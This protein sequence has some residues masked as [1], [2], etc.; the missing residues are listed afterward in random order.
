MDHFGIVFD[1]PRGYAPGQTVTGQ[2][3]LRSNEPITA[4]FL[5]ICF[6]G[7]AHT[8]W[9]EGERR[10]RTNCEGKEESYT[11][12][13]HYSAEVD[14]VSGETIA[15]SARNGT[16][17][18]PSGHHVFP[19]AFPLPIECPP[20]FEG[21]HGH[22]RYSVRVE[23]DRPWKFNKNE[24]E[25][26]KVIPNFDLNHLPLGNVP[27]MM[28]DVKDIGQI[29]K[30]GIVTI[31]VTIPKAGYAPG[32]YLPITIDIDNASKRAATFVRAELHQHSHYNA[33]KNHGLL[34]THSSYHEHHKDES[35]RIAEARKS[36]KIAPKTA[37]REMLRMKI[38]KSPPTFTSPIISIE[39]CLSVRLDT[40]TTLNNTLHCEFDIIIGTVPI[41][42][43]IVEP[44]VTTFPSDPPVLERLD[45]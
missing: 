4:R 14:Y 19:F 43:S 30:K 25:D 12:I 45:S 23:L 22:V 39:Y 21:F 44:T 32:E 16:E 17:K 27:R 6:H 38:P 37:G 1:S 33:S 7:A 10:Y 41:T 40:L 2:V 35:K 8:K 24:R 11:E 20:S 28:K 18:L 36:I 29:F 5:K 9:S 31:T 42:E 26:F 3:V 34:C 13:V 15:W